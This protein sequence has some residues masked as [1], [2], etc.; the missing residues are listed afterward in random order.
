[1][2]TK[3]TPTPGQTLLSLRL[4]MGLSLA[5]AEK[6]SGVSKSQ[7]SHIE[8]DCGGPPTPRVMKALADLYATHPLR[9][10]TARAPWVEITDA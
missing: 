8:R 6:E 1:M 5:L 4:E 3:R 2:T 7:I 9:I 10:W